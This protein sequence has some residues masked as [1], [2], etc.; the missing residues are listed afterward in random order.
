M[1]N[2]SFTYR[3][4][5]KLVRKK[6]L[7][8]MNVNI[9]FVDDRVYYGYTNKDTRKRTVYVREIVGGTAKKPITKLFELTPYNLSEHLSAIASNINLF[10]YLLEDIVN[11]KGF[12]ETILVR[13]KEMAKAK[14]LNMIDPAAR[15][16]VMASANESMRDML[17]L[18]N[19]YSIEINGRIME[20]EQAEQARE[21]AVETFDAHADT[22]IQAAERAEVTHGGRYSSR[23]SR[24]QSDRA[25]DP[26]RLAADDLGRNLARARNLLE[27]D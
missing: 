8:S 21:R 22:F 15:Q 16:E 24:A 6:G 4:L 10:Q 17:Q 23:P 11:K 25:E 13:A 1:F 5:N 19:E 7:D 26:D 27:R 14:T 9:P 18:A 2:R 12:L 3:Q 20:V